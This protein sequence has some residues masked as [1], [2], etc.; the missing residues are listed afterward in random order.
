[1]ADGGLDRWLGLWEKISRLAERA[2][3][4]HLDRKQVVLNALLAIAATARG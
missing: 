2:E 1:M 3:S 4:V